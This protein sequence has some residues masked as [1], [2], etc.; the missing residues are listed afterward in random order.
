MKLMVNGFDS[1]LS[2][3]MDDDLTRA[4]INSLFSWARASDE[5]VDEGQPKQGWWGDTFESDSFG[6]K[7]WLLMRST[8]SD[9]NET[10]L[11]AKEYSKE[12]LEWL[13]TDGV[14]KSVDVQVERFGLEMIDIEVTITKPDR[15]RLVLR[16]KDVWEQ[17]K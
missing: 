4:V 9:D 10:V 12:A 1:T 14:A 15:Q 11:R 7:L 17:D 6:S 8:L 16:F 3:Y 5:E 2:D 13:V